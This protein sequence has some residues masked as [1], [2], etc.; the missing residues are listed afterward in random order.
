[1]LD[2]IER[3]QPERVA[4]AHGHSP[5]RPGG[6][7]MPSITTDPRSGHEAEDDALA[8]DMARTASGMPGGARVPGNHLGTQQE[9]ARY[10]TSSAPHEPGVT[11]GEYGS[12]A[13]PTR[14]AMNIITIETY[15]NFTSAQ[16]RTAAAQ[17]ARRIELESIATVLR[18]IFLGPPRRSTP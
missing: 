4:S 13:T 10:P 7:D 18:D 14:A 6:A 2:L 9:T 17:R 5:P 8:L 1:L 16:A 3:F 15:A 11:F 12:H